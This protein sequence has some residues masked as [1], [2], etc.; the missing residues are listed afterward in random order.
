[1]ASPFDT[2]EVTTAEDS[3]APVT[4]ERGI[5]SPPPQR[6]AVAGPS[7]R[8]EPAEGHVM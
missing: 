4:V 1:M 2:C 8:R 5:E 3:R 7:V 6:V